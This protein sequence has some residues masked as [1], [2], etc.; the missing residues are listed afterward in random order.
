MQDHT[1]KMLIG[2]GE[3]RDWLYFFKGIQSE[4]AHEAGVVCQFN[5]WHQRLGHPSL[6][7]AK[8]ISNKGYESNELKNI[9]HVMYVFGLNKLGMF[10]R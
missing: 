2:A 3:W 5:L 10:F 8:L 7:I 1:S 9:K 6:R 4:R